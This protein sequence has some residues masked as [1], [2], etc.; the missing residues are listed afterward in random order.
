MPKAY[1][2]SDPMKRIFSD[3]NNSE[4]PKQLSKQI[5]AELNQVKWQKG[6]CATWKG[7]EFQ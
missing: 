6:K 4:T 5:S 2:K 3:I 1:T 7:F